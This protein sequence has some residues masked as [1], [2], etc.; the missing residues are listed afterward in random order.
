SFHAGVGGR[1]ASGG[2]G[3][4]KILL[5]VD[6]EEDVVSKSLGDPRLDLPPPAHGVENEAAGLGIARKRE[7]ELVDVELELVVQA[8]RLAPD[9]QSE[10][11][12]RLA[13]LVRPQLEELL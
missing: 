6:V 10:D 9:G 12:Q 5:R 1:R 8:L 4:E 11:A 13:P 3:G 7:P 2:L